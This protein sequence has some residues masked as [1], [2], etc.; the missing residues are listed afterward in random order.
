M[1]VCI[2]IYIY[3]HKLSFKHKR[4]FNKTTCSSYMWHCFGMC[5]PILKNLKDASCAYIKN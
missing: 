3:D 1:Y 4:Y 5:T 2:Y